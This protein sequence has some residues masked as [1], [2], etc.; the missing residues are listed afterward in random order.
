VDLR[1][2]CCGCEYHGDHGVIT[3]FL[4]FNV[5]LS[6]IFI[7]LITLG[8]LRGIRESGLDIRHPTYVFIFSFAAMIIVGMIKVFTH[9]LVPATPPPILQMAQPVTLWLVLRSFSAGAVAMSGTEAI[10]NGVPVFQ[11]EPI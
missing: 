3:P 9:S 6:L 8:N 11:T 4:N 5:I 1:L 2:E 7:G 10:S